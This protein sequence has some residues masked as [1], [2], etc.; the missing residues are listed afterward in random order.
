MPHSGDCHIVSCARDGYVRLA[1]LSVTGTCKGTK[2]LAMHKGAAHKVCLHQFSVS[3]MSF[4]LVVYVTF[5]C[6]HRASPY[7]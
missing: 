4:D 5:L 1:Q 2:K 6:L 7:L 3:V